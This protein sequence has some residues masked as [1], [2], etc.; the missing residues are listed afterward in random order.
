MRI[1]GILMDR[2]LQKGAT[3]VLIPLFLH[4]NLLSLSSKEI[5]RTRKLICIEFG[6]IFRLGNMLRLDMMVH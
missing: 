5:D 1:D 4:Y 6:K 2:Y 3:N